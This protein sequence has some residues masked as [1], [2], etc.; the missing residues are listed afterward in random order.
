M[1]HPSDSKNITSWLPSTKAAMQY[2]GTL[3][4]VFLTAVHPLFCFN[5]SSKP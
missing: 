3:H 1:G 4:H 5:G 2:A